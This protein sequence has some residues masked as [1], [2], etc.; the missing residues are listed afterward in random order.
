MFLCKDLIVFFFFLPDHLYIVD[1]WW[2]SDAG[3][4]VVGRVEA[5]GLSKCIASGSPSQDARDELQKEACRRGREEVPI[6]STARERHPR[7]VSTHLNNKSTRGDRRPRV[8]THRM[9]YHGICQDVA[10][11]GNRLER[12]DYH[13]FQYGNLF[14]YDLITSVW[15]AVVYEIGRV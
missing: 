3:K 14:L 7:H 15:N 9:E 5:Y 6:L 12:V 10:G 8:A 2:T 13:R 4:F 11:G 1:V